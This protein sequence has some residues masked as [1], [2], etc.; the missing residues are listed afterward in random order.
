MAIAIL[1]GFIFALLV[2][3]TGKIIHD[4]LQ[5]LPALLPLSLFIW[6]S[7]FLFI[8]LPPSISESTEWAF[9]ASLSF[10][11]DGLSLI[12]AL[13]ITG[14][15]VLVFAY[16]ATYMKKHPYLP[17]FY[18]YLSIFMASMLG[19]VLSG[20]AITLFIFWELT[21]I[22]SFF[23]IGFNNREEPSRKSALVA[24]AVTGFGGLAL[25]AAVLIMGYLTGTYEISAMLQ[26]PEVFTDS[27]YF[28]LILVLIL[29]AA[30]TKS[31]QFPFHF[32]LPGAMKAPTPVSTYLHS[33]TMVKAGIYLLFR[34][35]PAFR[36]EA[37]WGE[38]LM[39]I[40]AITM[41]YGAFHSLLRSDLKGILAYTTISALGTLTFLIGIG[42]ELAITAALIFVM[43][44][45]LYKAA[46]F[47][48]A[49]IADHQTHTRDIQLLGGL[50]KVMPLVSIIAFVSA[51][52][53][54]GIPLTFGFIGKDLIYESTLHSNG[55][56]VLLTFIALAANV[57]V[58][59]AG[60]FAG[61][62]PFAGKLPAALSTTVAPVAGLW[63]PPMVL[64]V[65][66]L[67]FGMF[68]GFLFEPLIA[69]ALNALGD[70][71]YYP[72]LKLWHGF[73][74][75]FW[76]SMGTI[77]AATAIYLFTKP[78]MVLG[79]LPA[80]LNFMA[81]ETIALRMGKLY[82]DTAVYWNKGFQSG[83]L[84]YYILISISTVVALAAAV[85]L[86]GFHWHFELDMIRNVTPYEW[87]LITILIS[88]V[89]ITVLTDSRLT[90]VAAMGVIGFAICLIFVIYGA[91]DLA[92]TQ[93]S[94]DTLT[95]ILFVLVLYKLPRYLKLTPGASKVRDGILSILF[96]TFITG[97]VLDVLSAPKPNEVSQF[98][99]DNA[100]LLAKGKNVVN[101][102][103]VDFR[104]L[105]T[106]IEITVLAVA[107]I[108]VFGL[109]KLRTVKGES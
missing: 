107:A 21:S 5:F 40:G 33:A 41:L 97:I 94:I 19:L 91:P 14:V 98:Y 100:Y 82:T 17:R 13:L 8:G 26:N 62:K 11:C 4:K 48:V 16:C 61:I 34:F 73:N 96:G 102:I 64:A 68:P 54:A 23:L 52:S 53:G 71:A 65:L 32:W 95:V 89:F 92:M 35:S 90:A 69:P 75:V 7:T 36:S 78:Y 29:L 31:A 101:V 22:S 86:P 45:A 66:S 37:L 20:N 93:F 59:A 3:F 30:F 25:L 2:P 99:M 72:Q 50:R 67:F 76:L 43:V 108:G 105:D 58:G 104:G 15:G 88:S 10:V 85:H 80:K 106:M 46:L 51:L 63:L 27:P 18:A 9:G 74:S 103:L 49:G 39:V 1:A 47:L 109:L 70:V 57:L 84:R 12:F 79:H 55:S 24:L 56:A 38:L 77:A 83:Y 81:P 28:V 60:F 44:H 87:I 6:F 42:T